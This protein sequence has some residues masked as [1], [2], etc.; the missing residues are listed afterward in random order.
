MSIGVDVGQS[1]NRIGTV[2][3]GAVWNNSI[4]VASAR[5]GSIQSFWLLAF[6]LLK[7]SAESTT[8]VI[9]VVVARIARAGLIPPSTTKICRDRR[10]IRHAEKRDN[11]YIPI[12]CVQDDA[13]A[14]ADHA[15]SGKRGGGLFCGTLETSRTVSCTRG[16]RFGLKSDA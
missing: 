4:R 14:D 5:G 10:G 12:S 2:L 3:L 11:A 16:M 13:E 7:P 8:R 15:G 1:A 9:K 6:R